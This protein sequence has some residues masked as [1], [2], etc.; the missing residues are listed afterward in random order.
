MT[1]GNVGVKCIFAVRVFKDKFQDLDTYA[2]AISRSGQR[3]VNAVA[4]GNPNFILFSS[5]VGHTFAKGMAFEEFSAL[6]EQSLR[7]YIL[8]CRNQI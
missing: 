1:D 7:K 4:P 2:G 5:D 6:I 3:F 8:T